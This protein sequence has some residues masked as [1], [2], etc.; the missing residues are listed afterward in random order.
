MGMPELKVTFFY[1]TTTLHVYYYYYFLNYFYS[2]ASLVVRGR[3]Q[4]GW[5]YMLSYYI[6]LSSPVFHLCDS[7]YFYLHYTNVCSYKC[8]FIGK[9]DAYLRRKW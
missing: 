5:V 4:N 2:S 7:V 9:C 3:Q 6:K 8:I 1:T